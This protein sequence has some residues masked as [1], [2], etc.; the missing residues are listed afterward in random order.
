MRPRGPNYVNRTRRDAAMAAIADLRGDPMALLRDPE[1]APAP[2]RP[3][4]RRCKFAEAA[5][6]GMER[7]RRRVRDLANGEGLR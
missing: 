1:P 6:R 2:K 7:N 5:A 4:K 3:P